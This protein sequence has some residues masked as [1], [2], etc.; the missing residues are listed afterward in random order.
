MELKGVN[1]NPQTAPDTP[2]WPPLMI[3]VAPN[4]AT[5]GKADHQMLPIT[6]AEIAEAAACMM[7]LHVRDNDGRLHWT[8]KPTRPRARRCVTPLATN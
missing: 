5:W 6:P 1:T 8:L 2:S 7:H 3:A 4:G